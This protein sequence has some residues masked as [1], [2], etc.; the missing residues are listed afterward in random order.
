MALNMATNSSVD[1]LSTGQQMQQDDVLHTVILA[2][3]LV[4]AP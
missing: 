4:G 1:M 3:S 2:M